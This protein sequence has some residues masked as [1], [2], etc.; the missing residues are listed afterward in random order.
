M[1]VWED[2]GTDFIVA[3][4]SVGAEIGTTMRWNERVERKGEALHVID[5]ADQIGRGCHDCW[6]YCR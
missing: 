1:F 4:D 2:D 5:H 3:V 6:A